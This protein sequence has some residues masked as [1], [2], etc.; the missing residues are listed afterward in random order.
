MAL[1]Y[2]KS[3]VQCFS[4]RM[5]SQKFAGIRV[6][7]VFACI[8]GNRCA[9]DGRIA[10]GD[11]SKF[12]W[13]YNYHESIPMTSALLKQLAAELQ[14]A[15]Q[16][17]P[18]PPPPIV[19]PSVA[20]R[21]RNAASRNAGSRRL[22]VPHGLSHA[23]QNVSAWVATA[24]FG[25]CGTTDG[26]GD[27]VAGESGSHSLDEG[28]VTSWERATHV[29]RQLLLPC[30]RAAFA[31]VSLVHKDCS[32]YRRCDRL[33]NSPQ[34]ELIRSA[35]QIGVAHA[36]FR[37]GLVAREIAR[38]PTGAARWGLG[39]RFERCDAAKGCPPYGSASCMCAA[40]MLQSDSPLRICKPSA[41]CRAEPAS[42]S[43][44]P[45]PAAKALP[46]AAAVSRSAILLFLVF[47]KKFV[48]SSFLGRESEAYDREYQRARLLLLSLRGV[49]TKL[50]V[51][52]VV[53][54][55]R[56]PQREA[57]LVLLGARLLPL[58][59]PLPPPRW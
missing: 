28:E 2:D 37:S 32:W 14:V 46:D 19:C 25:Y 17:P 33:F 16:P 49:H 52:L 30:K 40:G 31:T 23:A 21:S 43:R 51:V 48:R 53:G 20:V 4:V 24:A 59:R 3:Y 57:E 56:N 39:Q 8:G 34:A 5:S 45:W 35:G 50:P 6:R 58:E 36:D 18:P 47:Q 44:L 15:R 9:A 38:N 12:A 42:P 29:C 7:S 22:L 11:G 13:K 1:Q 27:C 26:P 55:D 41:L 54:G 10:G